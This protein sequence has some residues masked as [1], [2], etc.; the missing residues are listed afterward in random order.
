MFFLVPENHSYYYTTE[1]QENVDIYVID[2]G[3]YAEHPDFEGRVVRGADFTGEGGGDKNGHGTH[4]AGIIG[5]KT[6]G[7]AK[8]VNIIE[9]K[10]LTGMGTGNLSAVIA[11]IDFAVNHRRKTGRKSVAN[12]SL[13][14]GF[15]SVLNSA[16]NA[17][18]ESGLSMIV[19]AGNT[20]SAACATSPAS[21]ANAITVGAIDD[22]YDTIASF[23]NWGSCVQVFASGVYVTSL[24]HHGD[25]TLALSGTSMASPTVAG[26]MAMFLALGDNNEQAAGKISTLA[27]K[28]AIDRRSILFRPRT[29]NLILYNGQSSQQTPPPQQTE[30]AISFWNHHGHSNKHI[31]SRAKMLSN[32]KLY[33]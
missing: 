26:I 11:G 17:A 6:Y 33:Y 18:V 30:T 14:A 23:S 20:N 25:G 24:A 16:V 28:D 15:N 19:A 13:G 27:T 31:I 32:H 1:G 22:R 4:V 12:L 3:I 21:A 10:V 29:P 2:T 7:A 8:G 5:S 9:V